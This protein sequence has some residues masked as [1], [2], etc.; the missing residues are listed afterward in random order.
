MSRI[1]FACKIVGEPYIKMRSCIFRNANAENLTE[2]SNHNLICLER[3]VD[4]CANNQIQLMR[5]GSDIIPFASH[6]DVVFNWKSIFASRLIKIGEMIK[7]NGLRVSMHPGQY[8]VL[9]SPHENVVTDSVRDINW[10]VDFLDVLNVDYSS[11]I[12][13]HIGGIYGDKT[14]SISRFINNLL[15]LPENIKKRVV[16]ENDEKNYNIEDIIDI[17]TELNVPAVFDVFHH[18]LL[19]PKDNKKNILYW[20]NEAKKTW[21]SEDGR[22]KIHYSQQKI[23]GNRG[24]HSETIDVEQF[25]KFYKTISHLDLDIM[26][27]VKDKN[28]SALNCMR[29]ISDIYEK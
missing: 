28:I 2:I 20:M 16:L 15:Q 8:T 5:I 11:K 23:N 18:E 27:E 9:N 10:H 7:Q 25:M 22:Q 14:A 13:L 24:S 1:G 3:M 17:C 26:L 4:Y 12:V 6:K 19:P 21:K 29:A